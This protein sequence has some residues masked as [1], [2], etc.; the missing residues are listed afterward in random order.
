MASAAKLNRQDRGK[1]SKLRKVYFLCLLQ[2]LG[3]GRVE[4]ALESRIFNIIHNDPLGVLLNKFI[5]L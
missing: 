1:L 5:Y 2:V 3:F 4:L